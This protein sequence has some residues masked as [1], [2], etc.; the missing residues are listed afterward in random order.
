MDFEDEV[1]L[2]LCEKHPT[3]RVAS[4]YIGMSL[5]ASENFVHPA[6]DEHL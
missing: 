2:L 6:P 3:T 4:R 5:K 1:Q